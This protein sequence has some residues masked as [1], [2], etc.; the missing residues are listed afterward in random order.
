MVYSTLI[1]ALSIT[2][3][4]AGSKEASIH[5]TA[6]KNDKINDKIL[7]SP[8]FENCKKQVDSI[9]NLTEKESKEKIRT[10]FDEAIASADDKQLQKVG[11]KLDINPVD[12]KDTKGAKSIREFLSKRIYEA[13][14]GEDYENKRL[15]ELKHID[16]SLFLKLYE[17]QVS[18]NLI[19]D[20]SRYCLENIGLKDNP[21]SYIVYAAPAADVPEDKRSKAYDY[22]IDQMNKQSESA[23]IGLRAKVV[24]EEDSQNKSFVQKDTPTEAPKSFSGSTGVTS[25]WNSIQEYR[26]CPQLRTSDENDPCY[27]KNA[28]DQRIISA[29]KEDE[30]KQGQE[31]PDQLG[32][33][34]AFCSTFLVRNMCEIYKCN[35]VY[36]WSNP[37]KNNIKYCKNT[38]GLS[39]PDLST[40]SSSLEINDHDNKKG[41]L[42]CNLISKVENYKKTLMAIDDAKNGQKELKE[43]SGL[44]LGETGF[45]GG[46]YVG[47]GDNG[48][49]SIDEI[50]SVSSKELVNKAKAL[51]EG[52]KTAEEL[53]KECF[54]NGLLISSK[55]ECQ[56]LGGAMNEQDFAKVQLDSEAETKAYL[57]RVRKLK[58]KPDEEEL[59]AML[60][61]HGLHDYVGKLDEFPVEDLVQLIEDKY[62]SERMALINNMKDRFY[63]MTKKK[64]DDEQS[65]ANAARDQLKEME[66]HKERIETLLNYSN[67]VSS[68]LQVKDEDGNEFK[69]TTARMVEREGFEKHADPEDAAEQQNY[70]VYFAD[71][72]EAKSSQGSLNAGQLVDGIL[73]I[74]EVN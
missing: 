35:N 57:E 8:I 41:Q 10:C 53:N 67:I 58:E 14:H 52:Q 61:K 42:A 65:I 64:N 60:I 39:A 54:E 70:E 55:D 26:Y 22:M 12:F 29:L 7:S 21:G 11:Q 24:F 15:K 59:E 71:T 25:F 37:N 46:E 51:G 18:K 40:R 19:L 17:S 62:K 49:K 4:F 1:L 2:M 5:V 34:Y 6:L 28:R 69:N 31:K 30:L 72:E 36:D 27:Y 16:H 48:S 32:N 68:Y 23:G 56:E 73:G 47:R 20:V 43:F 45:K 3:A 50:T 9:K 38:L 13:I 33:K 63:S 44:S 66:S 74:G